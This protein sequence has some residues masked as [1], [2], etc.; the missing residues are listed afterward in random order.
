MHRLDRSCVPEPECLRGYDHR[1]QEWKALKPECKRQV[2][3]ALVRFQGKSGIAMDEVEAES[4]VRCAYCESDLRDAGHIEHFRRKHRQR[5]D[6]YPELTFAWHNLFLSCD[7]QERCGRYKDRQGGGPYDS[8]QLIKPDED[9]PERFL[10]F[11]GNGE[12]RP[13]DSLNEQDKG[14][15]AETIRVFHLNQPKLCG[16]RRKAVSQYRNMIVNQIEELVSCEENF[17][18]QYLEEEIE[19]TRWYEYATA[20]KH[21]LQNPKS[22]SEVLPGRQEP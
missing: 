1:T 6:A 8:D 3:H 11:H 13:R 18:N 14:R 17:R 5:D 16:A 4:R 20:I 19:N 9:D 7:D 21:F 22:V 12:V 15:A 10:Y 2:R